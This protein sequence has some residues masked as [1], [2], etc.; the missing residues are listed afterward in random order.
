[1]VTFAPSHAV[2]IVTPGMFYPN[3]SSASTNLKGEGS[4]CGIQ[5]TGAIPSSS[6]QNFVKILSLDLDFH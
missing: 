5:E 2:L 6:Y 4:E 3:D 1:V